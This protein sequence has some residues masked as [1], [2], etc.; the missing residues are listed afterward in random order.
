MC[1][2]RICG[3]E[4]EGTRRWDS[5]QSPMLP[6]SRPVS[7]PGQRVVIQASKATIEADFTNESPTQGSQ[8]MMLRAIKSQ[9]WIRGLVM[10][11]VAT[12][13]LAA[14][15]TPARAG[16]VVLFNPTGAGTAA[17]S[18]LNVSSFQYLA[19]N[20]LA[21][22]G[23]N[24]A[25]GDTITLVYQ[26]ILGTINTAGGNGAGTADSNTGN[27]IDNGVTTNVQVVIEATFRETVTS[28]APGAPGTT[29]ASFSFTPGAPNS[30]NLYAQSAIAS[31]S[32]TLNDGTGKGFTGNAPARTTILTGTITG[33]NF[34]SSFAADNASFANP[35]QLDQHAGGTNTAPA[36]NTI[37]GSGNTS[38][39]V[40]VTS[41]AAGYFPSPPTI[42][43]LN[44]NTISS[45]VPFRA[46]EP[47]GVMW[48]GT[49]NTT[50]N[51]G[52]VNG[53]GE[54]FLLQSQANNDFT[55]FVPE[56]GTVVMALMGI[57]LSTLARFRS[58]GRREGSLSA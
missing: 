17:G 5:F 22:N 28:I 15:A 52:P 42:L 35:V 45:G 2:I 27:I 26:A 36:I 54:N 12:L 33:Q 49:V 41:V 11:S 32:A 10:A 3:C 23:G 18:V 34:T 4:G 53:L 13:G 57:S 1:K 46:V 7:R 44:F 58:R 14:F 29:V 37:T 16:D 56:P 39:T 30:V 21:I 19:G 25:V 51:L 9:R 48:D 24:V 38:L 55:A 47:E 31:N 20:A 43:Q 6:L 40:N 8:T 50:A